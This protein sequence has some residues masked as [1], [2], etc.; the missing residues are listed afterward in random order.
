MEEV[1]EE[2][3]GFGKRKFDGLLIE[4]GKNGFWGNWVCGRIFII[5]LKLRSCVVDICK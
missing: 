3:N 5:K 2:T 1:R 4:G